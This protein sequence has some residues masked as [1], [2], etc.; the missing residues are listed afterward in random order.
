M[1][2][3]IAALEREIA[4]GGP[5]GL[6]ELGSAEL[7]VAL[8]QALGRDG[9]ARLAGRER[10]KPHVFRLRFE[11]G[12]QARSFVVKRMAPEHARRNE[13]A[14]RRWLPELG[15]GDATPG[16]LGVAAGQAGSWVWHVYEDLGDWELAA[17]DADPERIGAAARA[18]ARIHSRFASHPMLAE[19]R[20][21]G[22]TYGA[23]FLASSVRDAIHA[24]ERLCPPRLTPAAGQAALRDRLLERMRL[25]LEEEPMRAR[26]LAEWG[27]PETFLHGDLW[28]TNTFVEPVAGGL[29]ARFVDWDRAGV[30]PAS[31]DLSA[32]LLR[33][34]PPHRPWILSRYREALAEDGWR[35][36][37]TRELNLLFDTAERAR[38]ANCAIW[39]A[40]ALL[41]DRATWG[42][43]S[44]AAV[45][46]WFEALAPVLPQAPAMK[47]SDGR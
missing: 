8:A 15:F 5:H 11:L 20:L 31:Y 42:F 24:L 45:E 32:F 36:P 46:G 44:L 22:V 40:I 6:R 38:Y 39:P 30:G 10:I 1:A 23:P 21:H 37:G 14:I 26:A 4:R 27:G 35:L 9:P 12:A 13:L 17:R 3:M 19:C 43:D 18:I 25:L 28:T 29:K 33:F 34:A 16:L 2:R 7:G 47:G 41:R